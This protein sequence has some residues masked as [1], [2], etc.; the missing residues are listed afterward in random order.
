MEGAISRKYRTVRRALSGRG[1]SAVHRVPR[2]RT[3][4]RPFV[5]FDLMTSP[6]SHVPH[7]SASPLCGRAPSLPSSYRVTDIRTRVP[8][9]ERLE[10][11][12]RSR[13]LDRG[14]ETRKRDSL[15]SF[16]QRTSP[17]NVAVYAPRRY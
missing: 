16:V 4:G 5:N 6:Y 1:I 10:A 17:R 11:E 3:R 7:S 2:A 9:R 12:A 8:T 15:S 14:F 13:L